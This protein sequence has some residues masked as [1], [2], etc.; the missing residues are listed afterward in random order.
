MLPRVPQ[1]S[2]PHLA[3]ICIAWSIASAA[4]FARVEYIPLASSVAIQHF[5]PLIIMLIFSRFVF[6]DTI[7][8]LRFIAFILCLVGCGLTIYGLFKNIHNQP[9]NG[10]I[11]NTTDYQN[12]YQNS[13]L[14]STSS[15]NLHGGEKRNINTDTTQKFL[16]GIV[17]CVIEGVG[18]CVV[19]VTIKLIQ[20]DQFVSKLILSF[21]FMLVSTIISTILMLCAEYEE[22]TLPK[23]TDDIIFLTIHVFAGGVGYP[24]WIYVVVLLPLLISEFVNAFFIPMLIVCQYFIAVRLQPIKPGYTDLAGAVIISI[25][26]TMGTVEEIFK[27]KCQDNTQYDEIE[28]TELTPLADE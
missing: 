13:T 7:S 18:E 25:G 27:I 17:I 9:C 3:V 8:R 16:L 12:V 5:A 1:A 21:W 4:M 20:R 22:M 6:N 28:N 26:F 23:G 19:S 11:L 2:L 15:G 10:Y 14:P 24:L